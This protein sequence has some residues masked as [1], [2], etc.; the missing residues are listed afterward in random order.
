[1]SARKQNC[2]AGVPGGPG[3]APRQWARAVGAGVSAGGSGTEGGSRRA[4]RRAAGGGVA[5]RRRAGAAVP[6]VHTAAALT[7]R[8]R[9]SNGGTRLKTGGPSGRRR[10]GGA[11]TRRRCRSRSLRSCRPEN[12]STAPDWTG[13]AARTGDS[14]AAPR[15]CSRR[16]AE[17]DMLTARQLGEP[18]FQVLFRNSCRKRWLHEMAT[19]LLPSMSNRRRRY[20]PLRTFTL[21]ARALEMVWNCKAAVCWELECGEQKVVHG[22]PLLGSL[23]GRVAAS[24]IFTESASDGHE[25]KTLTPSSL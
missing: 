11:P 4:A 17:D 7:R 12:A 3:G 18:S 9:H 10:R 16:K 19:L 1:V 5:S 8:W 20:E 23:W 15:C 14:P 6:A 22:H 21:W 2:I 13:G 25:S 24:V